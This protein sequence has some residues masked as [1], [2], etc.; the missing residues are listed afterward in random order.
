[1]PEFHR[2]DSTSLNTEIEGK[3]EMGRKRTT[4]LNSTR[5]VALLA[6]LG[7]L[8]SSPTALAQC[9][10]VNAAGNNAVYGTC[11]GSVPTQGSSAYIDASA[12]AQGSDICAT[13]Y[14]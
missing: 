13:L 11:S 3:S 5:M 14:S 10:L 12:V 8:V 4:R 6:F 9:T 1:M 2:A 7:G